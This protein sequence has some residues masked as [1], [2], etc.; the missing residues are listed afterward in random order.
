VVPEFSAGWQR[1]QCSFERV[2]MAHWP[3][4]GYEPSRKSRVRGSVKAAVV[5]WVRASCCQ[6]RHKVTGLHIRTFTHPGATPERAP[7]CLL[8][9]CLTSDSLTLTSYGTPNWSST[10]PH[11]TLK[12]YATQPLNFACSSTLSTPRGLQLKIET[13]VA[14]VV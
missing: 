5:T 10:K 11:S 8:L 12:S 2:V 7:R 3:R 13:E 1:S 9:R 6:P 4:D 14:Q